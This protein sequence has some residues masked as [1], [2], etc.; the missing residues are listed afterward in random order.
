MKKATQLR[1][2]LGI[3]SPNKIFNLD[4]TCVYFE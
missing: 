3:D 2:R 4:E 1:R